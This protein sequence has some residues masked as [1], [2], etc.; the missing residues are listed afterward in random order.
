MDTTTIT[1]EITINRETRPVA[2]TVYT[3][4]PTRA[5]SKVPVL[6]RFPTGAKLHPFLPMA[7]LQKDGSW[8]VS[9]MDRVRNGKNMITATAWDDEKYAAHRAAWFPG[10]RTAA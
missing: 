7:Y 8:R 2:F 6:G 5:F 9:L 10:G 3:F 4:D 1:L